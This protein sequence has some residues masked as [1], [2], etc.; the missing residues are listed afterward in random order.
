MSYSDR[1]AERFAKVC[2]ELEARGAVWHALAVAEAGANVAQGT[3]PDGRRFSIAVWD[4]G[5]EDVVVAVQRM[6]PESAVAAA[7]GPR[8]VAP[9]VE[10][11]PTDDVTVRCPACGWAETLSEVGVPSFCRE[12]GAEFS[13][14]GGGHGVG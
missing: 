11:E 2:S 14:G 12:C 13:V 10:R 8:R 6:L 4:D 1:P 7:L 9:D 5:T 3:T